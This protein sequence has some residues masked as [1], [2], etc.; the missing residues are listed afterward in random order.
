MDAKPFVLVTGATGFV[1]A[2]LV[3]A[4]LARGGGGDVRVRALGRDFA[5]FGPLV[6]AGAEPV[7]ADLRDEAAVVAAC[8][9]AGV[10]YHVG[11]LSAPWGR[12]ADFEA[13][14]VGGTRAV[15]AG[16][17]CHGVRRLVYVSS[18]SVVFD[19]RDQVNL[20]GDAPFPRR[21]ASVYARTKKEGEDLVNAACSDTLECV[22]V[23]P[24]AVFG[25]GDRAL[26]PRLA[27]AARRGR[28]PQIGDGTNQV[29]L[30]YVENVADALLLAGESPKAVGKT[31][32][33]TNGEPVRLWDVIRRV[34]RG[35]NVAADLRPVSLPAALIAA[36]LMETAARVTGRE[37]TLTRY[38]ALILAR[39]QTYDI[40][41]A[42]RDLGYAPRV[43][44]AE[45]IERTI[46]AFARC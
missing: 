21:F 25:P 8:A 44:L 38:T 18:P 45:G 22:I 46:A 16:C 36:T 30:T 35:L 37:P 32:T 29:D 34:L 33:I 15:I 43:P 20:P 1:G 5:A 6:Q 9:G 40:S 17:V 10:V 28:L 26:L 4:L 24:K 41:P 2:H 3:R 12:A 11:A 14:N 39:T 42:R 13:V 7:R 27:E 23:R 19:G 31:Y